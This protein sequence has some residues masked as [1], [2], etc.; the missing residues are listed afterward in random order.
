M[1]RDRDI[2]IN[3]GLTV[4]GVLFGV[5]CAV[6]ILTGVVSGTLWFTVVAM[7][8]LVLSQGL[9]IRQKRRR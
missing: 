4:F 8:L 7:A 3:V 9:T 5:V 1:Q 2:R 6:L